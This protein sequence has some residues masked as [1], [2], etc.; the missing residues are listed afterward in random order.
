MSNRIAIILIIVAL[1]VVSG[2]TLI[3]TYLVMSAHQREAVATAKAEAS[4]QVIKEKQALLDASAADRTK[5]EQEFSVWKKN[6]DAEVAR[7]TTTA[8]ALEAL[9][10]RPVVGAPSDWITPPPASTPDAP[11]TIKQEAILPLY[12]QLAACDER[13]KLLDKC[14]SDI[15]GYVNDVGNLTAQRDEEKEKAKTWEQAAKGGSKMR[16]FSRGAVKVIIGGVT[17]L[18]VTCATGHCK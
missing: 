10:D 1:L 11:S 2:G 4:D 8:Q 15:R 12:K 13:E 7:I 9:R 5:R 18:A 16:R 14:T 17:A 6:H 3:V